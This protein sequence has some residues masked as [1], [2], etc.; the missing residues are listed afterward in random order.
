MRGLASN[1]DGSE[2][3]AAFL[4]GQQRARGFALLLA[5]GLYAVV[6]PVAN[7][8]PF[9]PI[10][11]ILH[12]IQWTTRGWI[13]PQIAFPW[14]A[15]ALTFVAIFGVGRLRATDVGWR[16]SAVWPALWITAIF[17]MSAQASL[18]LLA[19]FSREELIWSPS[20]WGRDDSVLGSLLDQAIGNSLVE[21]TFFRGFLLTQ[22]YLQATRILPRRSALGLTLTASSCIFAL[23]HVPRLWAEG[24]AE[25]SIR[26]ELLW[27]APWGLALALTFVVTKN[28]FVC[29]GLH[30]LWNA[31]PGLIEAPWERVK[32]VWWVLTAVLVTGW[33]WTRIRRRRR[34]E[35]TA[36]SDASSS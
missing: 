21:E 10:G 7:L 22:I 33:W 17:W 28:L 35:N 14:V 4:G 29:V 18:V 9:G 24:C 2:G 25:S 27:I 8:E 11:G 23:S 3:V 5:S 16:V 36:V 34:Q 12:D 6:L 30:T 19:L 15:L 31:R 20:W 32:A 13:A 26:D 1:T